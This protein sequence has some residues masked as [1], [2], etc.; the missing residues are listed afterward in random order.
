MNAPKIPLEDINVKV[1]CGM[2]LMGTH[3][4]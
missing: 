1:K 2:L 4:S 3:R